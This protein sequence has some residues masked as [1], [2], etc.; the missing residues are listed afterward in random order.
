MI[1]LRLFSLFLLILFLLNSFIA[2]A[3]V[4]TNEH[5]KKEHLYIEIEKDGGKW[6]YS[7]IQVKPGQLQET[8]LTQYADS[9]QDLE[10]MLK[11]E[12]SKRG[13]SY[14]LN[15]IESVTSATTENRDRVIWQTENEWSWEW[16]QKY[17]AWIQQNVDQ[18]FF[19]N[20]NLA[21]DCADVAI[22]ARWIFAR[23]NKLPAAQ[24]LSG[25]G[26]LFTN[27][28]FRNAWSQLPTH[29]EWQQDQL[30]KAAL[31]YVL[32][33]TYTHSLWKDSYSIHI[34]ASTLI[35]GSYH[36]NMFGDTGHTMLYASNIENNIKLIYSDVPRAIRRLY[37][38]SFDSD[39]PSPNKMGFLKMR[40]PIKTQNGWTLKA[41]TEMPYYS[42]NQYS[43]ELV[44]NLMENYTYGFL[45]AM[46]FNPS[47]ANYYY[48]ILVSIWYGFD[49]R[50][51]IVT[52]GF[53]FCSA[54]DCSPGTANYAAHSTP[55]R[56]RRILTKIQKAK[57]IVEDFGANDPDVKYYWDDY[58]S[59]EMGIDVGNN[60]IT[61]K[62]M[63]DLTAIW[64]AQTYSYDPRDTIHKRW[65]IPQ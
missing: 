8:L 48:D 60:Q 5:L 7:L 25:T 18:D 14:E 17:A 24:T 65:G 64:E 37:S 44:N 6:Y 33:N 32:D 53:E 54:N 39:K 3:S 35:P 45:L 29:E 49:D 46:G 10:V 50:Q 22:T 1:L 52:T 43:D 4:L 40:W 51:G 9:A 11:R 34:S 31:N 28:S 55:A 61:H 58:L 20:N 16:E 42:L 27:E 15:V 26:T 13:I 21:T 47:P 41:R 36:L 56:D 38:T 63:A 62:T 57:K 12:F 23:I 19:F 30:F 59:W 2:H